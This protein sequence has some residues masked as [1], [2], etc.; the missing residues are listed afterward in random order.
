MELTKKNKHG[1]I[2]FPEQ[3]GDTYKGLTCV[4]EPEDRD[5]FDHDQKCDKCDIRGTKSCKLL[6]CYSLWKTRSVPASFIWKVSINLKE[7]K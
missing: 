3:E 2:I 6:G 7:K 5:E 1:E 4:A